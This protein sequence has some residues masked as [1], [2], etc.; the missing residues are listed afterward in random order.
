MFKVIWDPAYN[1]V[2]LTM[3]S[4]GDALNVSPRPVFWEELDL[5]GL[6]K[7]GWIYPHVE[8]P[9]M[10]AC[11]RRYFY[12]GQFVLEVKGGNVFD[13]PEVIQ[14]EG[15]EILTLQP[16]DMERLRSRNEDTMF[17][18]EHEAMD[19]I[20]QTYRRYKNI[21]EVSQK[22]PDLDFQRLASSLE[23]K[24][25]EE[26]VVIKE[27]C[28]SF[29]VMPLSKAEEQGKAPILS[30]NTDIF[31]T[32][33][34]G[35]KDSQVV[36]DL[37]TRVVPAEDVVVIYSD[38]GYEL[39]SSLSLYDEVKDFYKQKYPNLR[40]YTAKNHQ[41]VLHYWDEIGTPSRIHRWCC[42]IMK[43]APL[44]KLLKDIVGNGK[45]PNAILF[46]GVRA[47]ES[48]SRSSR[49]R[50]G[51]NVKHNK[52]INV[53]PILEW[54]ATEIYLYLL[55]NGLPVNEAYRKGLSRV[56]C[57]ICPYSSSWSE[58][59]CGQLYPETL[60]PFVNKIREGL[61]RSK[62][63]G[64]E[65][66]IRTGRWKM[67]A[68]GRYLHTN[69]NVNFMSVA[70]DFKAIITAPK[71]NLLMWMRV[72]GDMNIHQDGNITDIDLK[73]QK[74]I[75]KCRLEEKSNSQVLEVCGIDPKDIVFVSHLKKVCYKATYCVHCEVC[76]V[77]CPTG[78]L[79]VVPRATINKEK[80]V[81]CL[82]CI[83]FDG[84]GCHA[85][86][87]ISTS[88]TSIM[89]NQIK[90][91]AQGSKSGINRYNDGMGMREKWVEK[92]FDTYES[93][94]DNN[95]HGLNP[96]Y[97]IPPFINWLR[98]GYILNAED[99]NISEVGQYMAKAYRTK[100]L[101]VWELIYIGLCDNSEICSWFHSAIDFNRSYTRE[102]MDII[103]QDSYP[104]LKDRTLRNPFNSLLNTFKESPLGTSIPVGVLGKEQNKVTLIRQPHNNIS[105]EGL[106]YSLYRYAERKKRYSLNVSEFYDENQT[107]GIY[108]QFGISKETL[109]SLLL[110]LQEESNHVLRVELNM[111]LD[112]IILREDLTSVDIL[113]LML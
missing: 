111:G 79:S 48:P 40:F 55:L 112:N 27:D 51:K 62:T 77:E 84:K 16:V 15:Y 108:R 28:D 61:E 11:D 106:A 7:R 56:G 13:A 95:E 20:N 94:F 69:A 31:V 109:E 33:F 50:I 93:F 44:S 85:A 37:V 65:N 90:N 99:K 60:A 74:Q 98:E 101:T 72:L 86:S 81:H 30:S 23:K 113:K 105:L 75:Y 66:Y 1:G 68:G 59:L 102:E 34:S 43:S 41:P 83:D 9:L 110:S 58:D 35:G 96:K 19:F 67:R 89:T 47:E 104:D 73:H 63:A 49:S 32:S 25:K 91:V 6:N 76:E 22:N 24:T 107:E 36:L 87:S 3:S 18:I 21:R 4:K 100:A 29:D 57:V 45:Q 39:P 82:K 26:H 103:L 71:E 10:W 8:E 97:Q 78:A 92:Y 88:D 46:D 17:I 53:S 38:T 52:I 12:K 42:S 64:I 5:L 14:Q 2:R 70:P 80:C 54:N